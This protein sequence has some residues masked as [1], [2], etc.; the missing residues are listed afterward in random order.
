MSEKVEE[1]R[2]EPELVLGLLVC[3][4]SEQAHFYLELLR[5]FFHMFGCQ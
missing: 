5:R 1:Q 2:E 4:L 3:S